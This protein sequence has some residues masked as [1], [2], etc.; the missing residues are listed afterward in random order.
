M[1]GDHVDI[2]KGLHRAKRME[3]ANSL[4]PAELLDVED[5]WNTYVATHRRHSIH[6]ATEAALQI[7]HARR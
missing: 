4:T 7:L 3:W 5:Q 1:T 2:P 6:K